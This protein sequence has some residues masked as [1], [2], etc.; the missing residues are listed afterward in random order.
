MHIRLSPK[1]YRL[2]QGKI[3]LPENIEIDSNGDE[4]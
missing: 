3:K 1:T 2:L 4:K